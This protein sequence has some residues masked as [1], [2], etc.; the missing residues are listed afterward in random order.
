MLCFNSI[1]FYLKTK[2][3]FVFVFTRHFALK[4]LLQEHP[5]YFNRALAKAM[6]FRFSGKCQA[7]STWFTVVPMLPC[8][9]IWRILGSFDLIAESSFATWMTSLASLISMFAS[10]QHYSCCSMFIFAWLVH[11]HLYVLN[12]HL[13]WG[14]DDLLLMGHLWETMSSKSK[15]WYLV[16]F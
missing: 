12:C 7:N 6:N 14:Q 13:Y 15:C 4:Q 10:C 16:M 1:L 2:P 11:L 8:S 3:E 9:S 5:C